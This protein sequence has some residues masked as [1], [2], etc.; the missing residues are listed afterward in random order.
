MLNYSES[1]DRMFH[2]LAD[3]TRRSVVERLSRGPA[4][5]SDLA[6]P[7]DMSL[8]A[9]VQH[10]AVLEGAGVVSSE[11]VGRVRTYQLA[12]DGLVPANEWIV[13]QRTPPA[14]R[15]DRLGDHLARTTPTKETTG[16]PS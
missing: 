8:P 12:P 10:L 9:V 4:S 7:F 16:E 3:V 6:K 2:A 1:L 15:L 13:D 5:V 11:K 14:K